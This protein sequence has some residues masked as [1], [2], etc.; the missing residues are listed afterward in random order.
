MICRMRYFVQNKHALYEINMRIREIRNIS[1]GIN[2]SLALHCAMGQFGQF[3]FNSMGNT[4]YPWNMQIAIRII[5][6]GSVSSIDGI[7]PTTYV[8]CALMQS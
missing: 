3:D 5:S 8:S 7:V 2:I 4:I 1:C 6:N